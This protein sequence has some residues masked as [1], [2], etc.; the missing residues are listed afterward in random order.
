MENWDEKVIRD[1]M[2]QLSQKWNSNLFMYSPIFENDRIEE[3]FIYYFL[4]TYCKYK[5]NQVFKAAYLFDETN[6]RNGTYLAL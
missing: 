1:K 3:E 2:I 5:K 6:G 4:T